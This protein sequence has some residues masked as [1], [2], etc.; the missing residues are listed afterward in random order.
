MVCRLAVRTDFDEVGGIA[1]R[2]RGERPYLQVSMPNCSKV[3]APAQHASLVVWHHI[4]W[5]VH[6]QRR[7]DLKVGLAEVGYCITYLG[8]VERQDAPRLQE[9]LCELGSLKV[10]Q[11]IAAGTP[12][13]KQWYNEGSVT[14][15]GNLGRHVRERSTTGSRRVREWTT[16]GTEPI[17]RFT[18][19]PIRACAY[20]LRSPRV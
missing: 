8:S 13:A 11:C 5:S 16:R 18:E 3:R 20:T 7:L 12:C 6:R 4:H 15:Q 1:W 10:W 2:L 17:G 19:R 9:C 14:R